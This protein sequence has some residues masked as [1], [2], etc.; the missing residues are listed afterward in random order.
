MKER[1]P[2]KDQPRHNL[3]EPPKDQLEAQPGLAVSP[4]TTEPPKGLVHPCPC[5]RGRELHECCLPLAV[6]LRDGLT[7]HHSRGPFGGHQAASPVSELRASV[8]LLL[9]GLLSHRSGNAGLRAA[10]ST[11]AR[12]FWGTV[13]H[14]NPVWAAGTILD[15]NY[16]RELFER[17]WGK[18]EPATR[19]WML[20]ALP[21][22]FRGDRI[23][24]TL[25]LD[26]LLWDAPWL[27]GHPAGRWLG[28]RSFLG[29]GEHSRRVL[30]SLLR[31]RVGL[32]ALDRAVPGRGLRLRDTVTGS[33]T[34]VHT[35]TP[36][37]N[38]Q[39]RILALRVFHLGTWRIAAGD[40]LLLPPATVEEVLHS[41]ETLREAMR[42]P[43]WPAPGWQ[44]WSKAWLLPL[45][46]R[47]VTQHR[48][49]RWVAH[50]TPDRYHWECH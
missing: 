44:C 21:P 46:A 12:L 39:D 26:W 28:Q 37:W 16:G 20:A 18:V 45:L 50:P 36:P 23:L 2:L 8:A 49:K 22:A 6:Q 30:D 33:T 34:L 10:H 35:P 7:S 1:H 27:G 43:T 17:L 4:H 31:S 3:E 42:A 19:T 24:G 32:Y 15:G 14:A 11:A 47:H 9:W 38:H 29:S 48:T 40:G 13:M 41:L 5:G 25:A